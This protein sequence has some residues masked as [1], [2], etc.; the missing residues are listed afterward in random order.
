MAS[1]TISQDLALHGLHTIK[2]SL[3]GK[4]AKLSDS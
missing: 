4:A 3:G 2:M 1:V